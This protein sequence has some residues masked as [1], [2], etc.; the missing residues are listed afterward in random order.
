MLKTVCKFGGSSLK[1]LPSYKK[2]LSIIEKDGA[3]RYIVVSAPGKRFCD[4]EKVTD[5]FGRAFWAAERKEQSE[6]KKVFEKI[7]ERFDCFGCNI[8][9]KELDKIEKQLSN[10]AS[11]AFALSRGEY[12]TAKIFAQTTGMPFLDTERCLYIKNGKTLSKSYAFIDKALKR[13]KAVIPGFYGRGTRGVAVYP[14]GGGDITGGVIAKAV[15]ADAYE[16][17]TDV[18]GVRACNPSVLKN[19]KRI[20]K[21][22]YKEMYA[23]FKAG[24]SVLHGDAVLPLVKNEIPLFI[25]NTFD[26]EGGKTLV[27]KSVRDRKEIAGLA[28][29]K[30]GNDFLLSAVAENFGGGQLKKHLLIMAEKEN[31]PV[32]KAGKTNLSAFI[33]TTEGDI[34]RAVYAAYQGFF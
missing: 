33:R 32:L 7:R 2:V 4:D 12:L 22:S 18:N 15:N 29:R 10:G 14:R 28:V 34:K 13:E 26:E 20:E 19:P 17:W 25:G 8:T 27:C 5:L 16:N 9:V 24:A 6:F 3:R 1:D 30:K 31:I 21:L 11:L 23:L